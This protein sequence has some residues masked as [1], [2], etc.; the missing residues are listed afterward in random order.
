MAANDIEIIPSVVFV[1]FAFKL[2]FFCR[3]YGNDSLLYHA[4]YMKFPFGAIPPTSSSSKAS[5]RSSAMCFFVTL[6]QIY[7][8]VKQEIMFLSLN[9]LHCFAFYIERANAHSSILAIHSTV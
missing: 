7:Y 9:A 8:D 6:I 4:N 3:S 2:F 5:K 1:S